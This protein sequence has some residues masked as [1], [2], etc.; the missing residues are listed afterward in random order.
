LEQI[1]KGLPTTSKVIPKVIPSTSKEITVSF[2]PK[3]LLFPALAVFSLA[4]V[5]VLLLLFLP[6]KKAAPVP[7]DKPSLA[8]IYFENNSGDENLENWRSGLSEMLITDLSQSKFLHILSGDRIFG[9]LDKLN[10]LDKEKYSTEDLK[11]IASQG[12]VSHILKGNFITAGEKFIINV[13]LMRTDTTEVVSSFK[14]TAWEKSAS[15][16]LLTASR[17]ELNLI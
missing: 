14:R 8:V 6:G 1:E 11:K 3:K 10:L 16:I 17:Q 12:G 5:V 15:Q 7:T 2:Q 13:S 4:V 9:L